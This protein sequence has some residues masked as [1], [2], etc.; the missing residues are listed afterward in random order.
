M[1]YSEYKMWIMLSVL[2]NYVETDDFIN[3]AGCKMNLPFDAGIK[4]ACLF[5]L[6]YEWYNNLVIQ[7]WI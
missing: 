2:E 7:F 5:I 3:M 4:G 1:G 6:D